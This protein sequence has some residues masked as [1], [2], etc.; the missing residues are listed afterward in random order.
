MPADST[1]TIDLEGDAIFVNFIEFDTT[2]CFQLRSA[3]QTSCEDSTY[4]HGVCEE[5]SG[6]VSAISIE[7][8]CC[9]DGWQGRSFIGG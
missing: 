1:F 2:P 4:N 6:A 8:C 5:A 9:T 7:C 3:C